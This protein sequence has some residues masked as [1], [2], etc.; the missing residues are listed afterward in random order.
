[1]SRNVLN[2]ILNSLLL[3]YLIKTNPG[4]MLNH[5]EHQERSTSEDLL[6]KRENGI[7]G[8]LILHITTEF[9]VARVFDLQLFSCVTI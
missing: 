7:C 6:K 8:H 2:T 5:M 4:K 1:M 3:I 9:S